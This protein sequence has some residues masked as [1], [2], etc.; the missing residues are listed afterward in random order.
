MH[1]LGEEAMVSNPQDYVAG[2]HVARR[3]GGHL[4]DSGHRH[5][6]N[7]CGHTN[8][9]G[10]Q[11]TKQSTGRVLQQITGIEGHTKQLLGACLCVSIQQSRLLTVCEPAKTTINHACSLEKFKTTLVACIICSCM[12]VRDL[13]SSVLCV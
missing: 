12:Y 1:V 13:F 4:P 6:S 11:G 10:P 7:H 2:G 3:T 9:H 8:L 5:P